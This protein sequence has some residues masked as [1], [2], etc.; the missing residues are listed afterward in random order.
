MYHRTAIM[1]ELGVEIDLLTY[2]QGQ[3]VDLPGVRINRIP[4]FPFLGEVPAGPSY[5]KLF[6]DLFLIAWAI[7]L[8]LRNRY[9]IVHAHEEA[10]F[11]CLALKPLFRFRLVY[12]MHSSLPQ[13]LVNFRF[14]SSRLLIGA[15]DWLECRALAVADA[16]ITI[17]P[18]LADYAATKQ[19]SAERHFL[20]ENSILDP[21]RLVGGPGTT[22]Q[23]EIPPLDDDSNLVIYAGTLEAYQ[24][25]DLTL[26]AVRIL[27]PTV[28]K[29][30]VFF[31]GGTPD[32]V[33][34]YRNRAEEIGV[35]AIC[36]FAG[37]VS[38]EAARSW[39]SRARVQLSPRISGTNTP[40]KV[41][42]QLASGVAIVATNIYS[43]TQVLD[44]RVALLVDPEPESLA[45]GIARALREP[46]LRETLADQAQKLYS[47][48][49]SRQRYRDKMVALLESL[50]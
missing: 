29:L 49:Y 11:F 12:D 47:E 27:A 46:A 15:F 1:A 4:N 20:I 45:A 40:L 31:L 9:D 8:L 32:Q 19:V 21:V 3:D 41:Y 42:E 2:G 25:I 14:T 13:Q 24:G 37:R 48:R 6:L 23:P 33:D 39:I 28:P 44:D 18:D 50:D 30:H 43:H 22:P 35:S 26:E 17:C 34:H 38:Q 16:V 36:T 7:A 5:I 10:I